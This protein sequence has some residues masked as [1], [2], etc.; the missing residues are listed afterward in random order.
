MFL[1]RPPHLRHN[2]VALGADYG[3]FL[4]AMSF[5]SPSTILPA[6]AASLARQRRHRRHPAV[7]TLGWFLPRCL[8]P[9]TPRRGP[10]AAVVLR[11]TIGSACRSPCSPRRA[12]AG[13]RVA[14]LTLAL[15]LAC[16]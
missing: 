15:L 6:F 14:R 1:M 12:V 2:V 13:A 8:R 4:V 5:A 3:L 7:R 11:Y 9:R 10:E 16:W